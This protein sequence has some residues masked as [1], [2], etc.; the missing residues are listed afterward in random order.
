MLQLR[1]GA[2]KYIKKLVVVCFFNKPFEPQFL[3]LMAESILYDIL[4]GQKENKRDH[5]DGL[6]QESSKLLKVRCAR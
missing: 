4:V 1:S 5:N 3:L 2:A 6:K